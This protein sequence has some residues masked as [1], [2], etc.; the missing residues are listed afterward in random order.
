LLAAAVAAVERANAIVAGTE[1]S[2][3]FAGMTRIR[4]KGFPRCP[5]CVSGR[6][7]F[8]SSLPELPS[9]LHLM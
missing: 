2:C 6:G 7:G 1:M 5:F 9:E 4:F 3:P 8:L